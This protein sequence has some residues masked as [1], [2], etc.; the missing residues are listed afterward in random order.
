MVDTINV[1]LNLKNDTSVLGDCSREVL[2]ILET[3]SAL[4]REVTLL[5]RAAVELEGILVGVNVDLDARPCG[6]QTSNGTFGA[7]VV[8]TE[9]ATVD[10]EAGV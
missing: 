2:V 5:L 9:L 1:V 8:V 3:L 6:R 7:P 4:Q 10:G